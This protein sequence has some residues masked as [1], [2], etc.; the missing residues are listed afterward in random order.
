MRFLISE[1]NAGIIANFLRILC[2]LMT[3]IAVIFIL[4]VLLGRVELN[5]ITP[6]EH[7]DHA[8]L[9]EKDH[10]AT[11]RFLFAKI[12]NQTM[13][14]STDGTIGFI[15]WLGISLIGITN[16]FPMGFC[17]FQLSK[18]FK[19]ISEARVFITH[20]AKLLLT[21][22]CVLIIASLAAP[23]LNAF[24]YPMLINQFTSNTLSLSITWKITGLLIGA[25]LLV[26]SY[27][28]YYGI[29]LQD[30]A[31]HTL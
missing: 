24:V 7:F 28:F 5:I 23:I 26:M 3:S 18:F 20:N 8:L 6:T 19:N 31:D 1:K 16:A 12:S 13:F 4:L 27:V 14:L 29:Y 9:F 17:F 30:E 10:N 25:I 22:A 15:T 2:I 21:S 11:S